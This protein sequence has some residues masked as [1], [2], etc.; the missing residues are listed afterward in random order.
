M[1][2]WPALLTSS[3]S[4]LAGDGDSGSGRQAAKVSKLD[5]SFT[6]LLNQR[7][8]CGATPTDQVG[9]WANATWTHTARR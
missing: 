7:L 5:A 2:R 1:V 6:H 9:R 8:N 4:S 3:I